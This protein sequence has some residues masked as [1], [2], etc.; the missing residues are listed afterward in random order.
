M[1][2]IHGSSWGPLNRDLS[3]I[4]VSYKSGHKF[5]SMDLPSCHF[6]S[7]QMHKWEWYS[8]SK[9]H[10]ESCPIGKSCDSKGKQGKTLIP[11]HPPNQG[12]SCCCCCSVAESW[13]PLSDSLQ[14]HGLQHARLP[15]PSPSPRVHSNPCLLSCWWHPAIPFSCL[16]SFPASWSFVTG[17]PFTSGGQSIR[18]SALVLPMNIQGWFPLGLT[19]LI[20]L[21]SKGRSRV[22]SSTTVWRH[23]FFGAQPFYCTWLLEKS[24]K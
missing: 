11:P 9:H 19:G 17:Q 4:W 22:F 15:C 6:L 16:Q 10:I 24:C 23:Q 7:S 1:T 5:K 8:W 21:L 2:L 12:K 3:K 20:S 13:Q 14:P 18:A